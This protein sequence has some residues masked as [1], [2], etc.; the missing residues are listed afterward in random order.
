MDI[1]MSRFHASC[2][3][4]MVF[5][6]IA[7]SSSLSQDILTPQAIKDAIVSDWEA[8]LS[9]VQSF[10]FRWSLKAFVRKDSIRSAD[11]TT[12]FPNQDSTY[13]GNLEFWA[14]G[15]KYRYERKQKEWA[16]SDNK[17]VDQ[18]I[19]V[20]YD[21]TTVRSHTDMKS[22]GQIPSVGIVKKSKQPAELRDQSLY[23]F[24]YN[25]R[26]F[27]RAL[28]GITKADLTVV[29]DKGDIDGI[30][31]AILERPGG[32]LIWAEMHGDHRVRRYCAMSEGRELFRID[33]DYKPDPAWGAI[34]SHWTIYEFEV[35]RADLPKILNRSWE[36]TVVDYKINQPIQDE[37]FTILFPST[38]TIIDQSDA[39]TKII[40]VKKDGSHRQ[41]P[42]VDN[43]ASEEQLEQSEPGY[44]HSVR[45]APRSTAI[46]IASI[47]VLVLGIIGFLVSRHYGVRLWRRR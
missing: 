34:P 41:V 27:D 19:T 10:Q 8:R 21:G 6:I 4:G 42:S 29:G 9:Q 16:S 12:T 23:P 43:G 25:Y 17:F 30:R 38:T 14:S 2:I 44:A 7:P 45:I 15:A 35:Q 11:R 37:M 1:R 26:A 5:G 47:V 28:I 32:H 13:N 3:F 24:V 22:T 40:Y 20:T 39:M 33:I 46:V 31:C 18:N 36:Y